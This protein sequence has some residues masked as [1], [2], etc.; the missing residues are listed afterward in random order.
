MAHTTLISATIVAGLIAS[1]I[2]PAQTHS[3]RMAQHDSAA[4][5]QDPSVVDDAVHAARPLFPTRRLVVPYDRVGVFY[6]PSLSCWT[7]IPKNLGWER[8]WDC[9][10]QTFH[11][12]LARN[13][14]Y[15]QFVPPFSPISTFYSYGPSYP[16]C[17]AWLPTKLGLR[18]LNVCHWPYGLGYD[19]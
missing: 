12:E 16:S 18:R 14:G 8:A 11:G 7:W 3:G 4:S 1:S 9:N 13:S 15:K 17:W 10:H 19:Y 6:E 2:G 5:V